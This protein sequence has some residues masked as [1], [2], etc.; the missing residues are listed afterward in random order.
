MHKNNILAYDNIQLKKYYNKHLPW[1][2][3]M[4]QQSET[5]TIFKETL[6]DHIS[7]RLSDP[8][9][10]V[11]T[12]RLLRLIN[13]DGQTIYE[14]STDQDISIHTIE[15]LWLFLSGKTDGRE[16]C[17]LL[18]DL[19][20]L[21]KDFE[22][23]QEIA[24][25]KSQLISS[26]RRWPSGLDKEVIAIRKANKERIIELLIKKIERRKS[27][28]SFYRFEETDTDET[29]RKKVNEWWNSFR[30]HLALAI[31]SPTELNLFLNKSLS[32]ETMATLRSGR[33]KGMPFFVTPYYLSLL[34]ISQEGYDDSTIRSYILYSKDLVDTYGNIKAWER[35]D[36]IEEGMPNAA[37]WYLPDGSN[38]HRRYPEVAI[39]IP[40]SIGRA[41]GGL[42][43]SCQRMY[44]FQSKRLNFNFEQLKPKEAW[45][46]KLRRLMKYFEEDTQL[47]DILITGGDALM[48]QNKTLRNIL[49]AV[50]IMAERKQ[51]ANLARPDGQKYAE[52]QRVRLGSRLPAY[53]PFR[54]T[55]DLIEILKE[56]RENAIKVGIKQF[57][58]QSHFQSPLEIT[59]ESQQ[60]IQKLLSAGWII[61]NQLVFNVAASRRGHTAMLRKKLNEVG[62]LCYYTFS[63][64]GFQENHAVYAPVSR[65]I[66]EIYEEKSF[67]IVPMEKKRAFADLTYNPQTLSQTVSQFLKKNNLPFAS[68]DRSVL[69]LPAIGKSMTFKMVGITPQG[70]RIHL[71]KH[72]ET[73]KHSPIIDRMKEIFI[74]ENKSIPSYLR[75]LEEMGEDTNDYST[76]WYCTIGSTEPAFKVYD[77][78]E[79]P[80]STT[81]RMTNIE[82]NQ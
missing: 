4:A 13:Y 17:D 10:R 39:L 35:E 59:P 73:R 25:N 31:K 71:F 38:I 56:F 24:W 40:D 81:D 15:L 30:F 1:L 61:T 3:A 47:R 64:K 34:N 14:L 79:Y 33:T 82:I 20:T 48:S 45:N 36:I 69:N 37:G 6:T 29:K 22:Q 19:Y 5:L 42:C 68:T 23:P 62:V 67:G 57:I 44:D 76:L 16:N 70:Q 74:V 50:C 66:Q 9:F 18:L 65:S 12:K 77:Y 11:A 75:Q 80:F 49:Q 55:D 27:T 63:V 32:K 78:P 2:I 43:A 41:C 7:P 53:L 51:K 52:I 54:V 60:A 72:D 8:T 58:I 21:F 28:T 26:M 46:K